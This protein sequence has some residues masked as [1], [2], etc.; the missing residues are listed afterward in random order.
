V[1]A[2]ALRRPPATRREERFVRE[3]MARW[4]ELQTLVDAAHRRG[5]RPLGGSGARRLGELYRTVASDLALAQT[6]GISAATIAHLNRLCVTTHDLVYASTRE[7]PARRTTAFIASGFPA[8][9]RQTWRFHAL[10]A[11]VLFGTALVAYLAFRA[12]PALAREAV[13]SEMYL[14]AVR[15]KELADS[16]TRYIEMPSLSRPFFSWG[17]VANNVNVSLM[18]FAT[19]ALAGLGTLL[20]LAVN[21]LHIGGAVAVFAE[22]GVPGSILTFMSAHGPVELGAIC[23]AGGAGLRMGMSL[24]LPGQKPRARAFRDAATDSVR[25]LGGTAVML[26]VAGLLEAFVSPVTTI[27]PP[28]KWSVGAFTLVLLLLYFGLCGRRTLTATSAP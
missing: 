12:D 18:L 5:F 13:G 2:P 1:T 22:V 19:G 28:V 14:R 10:A 24:L 20:L 25:M 7:S 8:L 6:L 16:S 21:G 11:T 4:E 27:P 3:R 23:I 26:V 15:A 9:V 17:L